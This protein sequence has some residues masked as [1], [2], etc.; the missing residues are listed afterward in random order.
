MT[1]V[2]AFRGMLKNIKKCKK[3]VDRGGRV[4]YYKRADLRERQIYLSKVVDF[5]KFFEKNEKSC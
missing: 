3:R 1:F 2:K 5:K 4:W